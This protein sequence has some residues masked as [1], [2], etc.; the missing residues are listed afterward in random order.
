MCDI[1][2]QIHNICEIAFVFFPFPFPFF[3][4]EV[5]VSSFDDLMNFIGARLEVHSISLLGKFGTSG[6][7]FMR[8][9]DCVLFD[10]FELFCI[11]SK[12]I[13]HTFFGYGQHINLVVC[14]FF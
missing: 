12:T 14:I 2:Y 8:L 5:F 4:Q 10:Y 13:Q 11:I 7:V 6:R 9:L 3:I 1:C